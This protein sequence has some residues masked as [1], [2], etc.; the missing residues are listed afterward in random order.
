MRGW[1][2]LTNIQTTTDLY[3][4]PKFSGGDLVYVDFIPAVLEQAL[5][6]PSRALKQALRDLRDI[7]LLITEKIR[8]S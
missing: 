2:A 6:Q 8:Q 3:G 4:A 1:K 7:G 5:G